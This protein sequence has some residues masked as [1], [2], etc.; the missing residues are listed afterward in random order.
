LIELYAVEAYT[1]SKPA[2][3]VMCEDV[4]LHQAKKRGDVT[5]AAPRGLLIEMQGEGHI[6]RLLTKA[7]NTDSS[8]AVSVALLSGSSGTTFML[9]QL[10]SRIGVCCGSGWMSASVAP[11]PKLPSG[12][13]G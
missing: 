1:L 13:P 11:R 8:N 5:L 12:L 7:N 9:S 4:E 6:S 10:W 3:A 2:A